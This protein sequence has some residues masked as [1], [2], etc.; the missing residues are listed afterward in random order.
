[1]SSNTS[2]FKI[3]LLGDTGVGKT[4]ILNRYVNN[5][6]DQECRASVVLDVKQ[7]VLTWP[8]DPQK[9]VRFN[10]W[11]TPGADRFA[12]LNESYVDTGDVILH[13]FSFDSHDTFAKCLHNIDRFTNFD[14]LVYVIGNKCEIP[15]EERD[16]YDKEIADL[17]NRKKELIYYQTSAKENI[18]IQELFDNIIYILQRQQ[19]VP[20]EDFDGIFESSEQEQDPPP[21]GCCTRRRKK[22]KKKRRGC[23]GRRRV[24][25]TEAI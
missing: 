10:L 2:T 12:R 21:S 19:T 7:K 9:T 22:K 17:L 11:D 16:V 3:V 5:K 6:F 14:D 15:E 18:H 25:Y 23:F 24:Y 13:V 8:D 20:F 1:M 4:S